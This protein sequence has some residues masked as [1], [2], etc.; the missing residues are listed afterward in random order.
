MNTTTSKIFA[1]CMAIAIAFTLGCSGV[2]NAGITT[3]QVS[4]SVT[5]TTASAVAGST[6]TQQFTAIVQG[7]SNTAVTWT[8]VAGPSSTAGTITS[9]GLYTPPSQA[10]TN[11]VTAT[12]VADTTKSANATVTVTAAPVVSVSL[13]PTSASV[14]VGATSQFTA[15]VQNATNTSVTWSV[16]TIA[17][18]NAT[19]GTVNTSGLYTAPVTAGTHTVTATSVADTTK[20]ASASV[21]VNGLVISPATAIVGASGTQQ[22]TAAIANVASTPVNWFVDQVAGGNATVG[23]ISATGLYTAP[24]MLG[25]HTITA[26]S[27]ANSA[28]TASATI[29]V[30]AIS[31]S[32]T[33]ATMI[34]DTTQ[35]FTA[36]LQGVTNAGFTWS[37]TGGTISSSGLYTSPS[38]VGTY[39]VTATS[40]LDSAL[41]ASA[42]VSVFV[43]TISPTTATIAPSSTQ[44]FTATIQGLTNTSVTWS[45]DGIAD[46]NATTGTI[47]SGGL[48]SAPAAIGAHKVTAT[49]VAAPT[50]SVTASLTVI[51]VAQAAVLTYHNDDA[52][53]GQ[54]LEEVNLTPSNVN[55]TQFGK[56]LSYPVD[57][58]VYAQPLYISQ[59][60]I[61]G[62]TY[63]VVFVETQNNSVYA[64][65]ADAT[66][67]QT[68]QTFWHVGP[69]T[70]GP[71]VYKG[72][73]YGV[74]PN[75]GILSTPVIDASTNTMYLMVETSNTGPNGTPFF[76]HAINITTGL[77]QAGSPVAINASYNGDNL[78]TSCYQRMGLALSPVTNWIYI[79]F[80][81]CD[82]GW[83]VAYDKT[84]LAQ[85]AVFESTNGAGGG[86]FWAS[87]G[88]SA[89]DDTNGNVY[90][91]S[92]TDY[93]DQ[94]IQAP[95]NYSQVGYNDSFLN[96]N[97]TTLDV[98]SSF[99]PSDNYALSASDIDLGSGSNVLV[100][101]NSTY[102][103]VTIGG[104]KDGNVFV[105][106][107]LDMGG[108]TSTNNVIQTVQI[109]TNG[110]DNIF[111]TPVYWNGTIY[112]HC[113]GYAISAYSWNAS[114]TQMSTMPTS[115]GTTVFN[116]H[117]ATPSLSANGNT[118]GIIWDIDNSNYIFKLG[119]P[120]GP[121]VLH[122]YD[123]TNVATELY[124][125]SQAANGRDTAG[126]ALKFTVPT[127]ANGKVFVP[128]ST[129]LD[130]YGLLP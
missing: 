91:M 90:L 95:P 80:G 88:A 82:W 44:Q 27:A 59:L 94:W 115:K 11:T 15:T 53:D 18:G 117:G 64:F 65:D 127:I 124:N 77:D 22:F 125:S 46:G 45:V 108:F 110:N 116:T 69:S 48:Y 68:A 49:S 52:R 96:L 5:P 1:G 8:V 106:N 71:S 58:Q 73:L 67:P 114:T 10:G 129:E 23:T 123:A 57:G 122:A 55:S 7:S 37:A 75:V 102:P 13:S 9:A 42:T 84:S 20:S 87:G 32:P 109:C 81:S 61:A 112:Y 92:G 93:D 78:E 97:P 107:P 113:D 2:N 30:T 51:N 121:S 24:T 21:T 85:E 98:Q 16:D 126:Q 12:S 128:T 66:S 86:G 83:V 39:T 33:S 74:N 35:Q 19:V 43:F 62:G 118:N 101:G 79:P 38:T 76:L 14:A 70:L 119:V 41:T 60:S 29:T 6:T 4:V 28:I 47:T 26:A 63:D 100:P 3:T 105:L 31:L 89:I 130:V 25:A 111:S 72:D 104:G 99:T 36:T 103:L 120:Q 56:L 54:Y 17:G 34:G 50:F 40:T